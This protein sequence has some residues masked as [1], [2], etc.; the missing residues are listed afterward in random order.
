MSI[1]RWIDKQ[2]GCNHTMNGNHQ[3]NW[4]CASDTINNNKNESEKRYSEYKKNPDIKPF[5]G[6]HFY[7][8]LEQT[9]LIYIGRNQVNGSIWINC[10]GKQGNFGDWWKHSVFLVMV[11]V[12]IHQS[13]DL[14]WVHFTLCKLGPNKFDLKRKKNKNDL[15]IKYE[16]ISRI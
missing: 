4:K 14:R 1:N 6:R 2:I 12:K 5:N 8:I 16:K 7:E 10:S 11:F 9:K 3:T 15:Y 13:V